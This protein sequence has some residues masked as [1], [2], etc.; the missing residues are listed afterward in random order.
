MDI[1][2]RVLRGCGWE[3]SGSGDW[4]VVLVLESEDPKQQAN[5]ALSRAGV[6]AYVF[7]AE[8]I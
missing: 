4:L 3:I 6:R 5:T 1:A 7:L 2:S 8:E